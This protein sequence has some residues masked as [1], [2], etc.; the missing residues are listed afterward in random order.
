MENAAATDHQPA[1]TGTGLLDSAP[2]LRWVARP[3][4]QRASMGAMRYLVRERFATIGGDFWVTDEQGNQVYVVDGQALSL[5]QTF[6]LQDKSGAVVA[7][8]RNVWSWRDT[9]E[10]QRDGAVIAT[11]QPA[12]FSPL[13]HR[14]DIVLAD[15]SHLEA[16][17]NFF[18]KEFEIRSGDKVVAQVSRS[19][20]QVRDNYAVDVSPGQDDALLIAIAVCL[21]RI[22]HEQQQGLH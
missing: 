8:V 20:F 16:V 12:I 5:R 17:G 9:I 19:L 22:E 13:R 3:G 4:W 1:R 7:S 2:S 21:D 14:S 18:D 6:I 15:G 10:I 11:V